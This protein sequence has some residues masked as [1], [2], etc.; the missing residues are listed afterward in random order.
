MNIEWEK[1]SFAGVVSFDSTHFFWEW[2]GRYSPSFFL[3]CF[4]LFS[5]SDVTSS[6]VLVD[7]AAGIV[8][9]TSEGRGHWRTVR[10][11]QLFFL[12]VLGA[13]S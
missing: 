6:L 13:V 7:W 4:V 12:W 11:A 8:M 5:S 1:S 9:T 2:R 3:F 10:K